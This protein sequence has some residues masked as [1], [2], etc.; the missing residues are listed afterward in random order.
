LPPPDHPSDGSPQI[1]AA[2]QEISDRAALLVREE[3][4]LAKAEVAEKLSKLVRA[5]VVATAAGIFAIFAVAVALNGVAWLLY[6]LVFPANA[7]YWGFFAVAGGLFIVAGLAAFVA[8]RWFRGGTPPTPE[9]AIDE[10]QRIRQT[11]SGEPGGQLEAV[12]ANAEA[13]RS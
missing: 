12:A 5:A 7:I 9:M 2:I 10:A 8:A 11:L 13:Q 3:I 1:A 6:E 4:E